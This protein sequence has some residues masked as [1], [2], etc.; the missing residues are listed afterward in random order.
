M[1]KQEEEEEVRWNQYS[2]NADLFIGAHRR[3]KP[4]TH[5]NEK[6]SL[7]QLQ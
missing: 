2:K 5:S 1:K 3:N 4:I 7:Q 6:K